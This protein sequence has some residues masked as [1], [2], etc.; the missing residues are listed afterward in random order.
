MIISD[1]IFESFLFC[2]T[3]ANLK[4]L[5][6]IDSTNPYTEWE[7]KRCV[8]F[9]MQCVEN[10]RTKYIASECAYNLSLSSQG[11]QDSQYPFLVDC[12]LRT[13]ELQ[14]NFHALERFSE[15]INEKHNPYIPIRFI[16]KSKTTPNDKLL[17][18]FD[19]FVLTDCFGKPSPIGKIIYGPEQKVAKV[20]LG[21]FTA[22][23]KDLIAKI[24]TQQT[25]STSPSLILKKHCPECEF[26]KRCRDLAIEKDELTL[27]SGMAEKERGKLHNK[28]IFSVT[29]LSYT[30][31]ARRKP[32]HSAS[33]P[34]KYSHALKALA[35][36]EKKIFIVGK[37]KFNSQDTQV[38][39][40][41]EG[42]PDRDFYYLIGAYVKC[43]ES[44]VQHSFWADDAENERDIWLSLLNVLEKLENPQIIHYGHYETVFLRKMR[45]RYSHVVNVSDK[46]ID[47][48]VN[49][50]SVIYSQ[51]YFP[52]YSNGLKD[53][54]K[55]MGFQWSEHD[56]T[57]LS[58][59]LWRSEWEYSRGLGL[60]QKLILYNKEDCQ[61]LEKITATI[62]DLC[63]KSN[64]PSNP[65]DSDIVLTDCL[66]REYPYHFEKIK[67]SLPELDKI[68]QSAY[69]DY[70][71]EK[72][73]LRSSARLL[74]ISQK[75][76]SQQKQTYP[77]NE[78]VKCKRPALCPKCA[79]IKICVHDKKSRIIYDLKFNLG[80]GIQRWIVL[81]W[82]SRYKCKKCA[83]IFYSQEKPG[84]GKLG[85]SLMAYIIYQT[86]ELRLS[87]SLVLQ[88]LDQIFGYRFTMNKVSVQ[89][90]KMAKIYRETYD[91]IWE[92]II[93]GRLI[94]ADET[95][96][97]IGK[98]DAY[99]WTFTNLEYVAYIYKP[100]REGDFLHELL[101]EF[102]G[103]LVSDFYAA[104]D[105]V[106]CLQ[107]K[108]LIHLIRDLNDDILKNP[109]DDEL[110]ELVKKFALLLQRIVATI[111]QFGLKTSFLQ[112]HKMDI[113]DFYVSLDKQN[114]QSEI[115]CKYKK[116]LR[117]YR[118]KLFTFIDF[119]D[120]PWN[121]NN[122]E[123]AIKAFA[124]IREVIGGTSTEKGIR[125]YLT[126]LSISETCQY[127]DIS[128]LDFLLS[129]EMDLDI[130]IQKQSCET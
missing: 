75:T 112:K 34:D 92:K 47:G 14:S 36:R 103:V 74:D 44:C 100:T 41:V 2:K 102:K 35:I 113:D 24:I 28:G 52:T 116:R 23:A 105:S 121:N 83:S 45:E 43:K 59:L 39:L 18:A 73:Y 3:K 46:L 126:L 55:F 71:R 62:C 129:G 114:F 94:H 12:T 99:V 27:L 30:F 85:P 93:K 54:A 89:K 123:H 87:Q 84:Q 22:A 88:N 53:I 7:R 115:T 108:C 16:P 120:I 37:P 78:I 56:A 38:F 91:R 109:F 128:F 69:W 70:Q 79:S 6:I 20:D 58:T 50:L 130:F 33:K 107:Q 49:L 11:L 80:L 13:A 51:V 97:S 122:A 67:F 61:A 26:H 31:R 25:N 9:R 119:D 81:Y 64:S 77:I 1:E 111:D 40:D 125:E 66:K 104:Y 98:E 65:V 8:D 5:G 17:L 90:E 127:K 86:I 68:N 60:K 21:K 19:A 118:N 4:Y 110:K 82:Y 95:K 117:K 57:G 72:I 29:Q 15:S 63:L 96:V 124:M 42:D 101:K 32:K 48:A 76:H 10:L 106:D